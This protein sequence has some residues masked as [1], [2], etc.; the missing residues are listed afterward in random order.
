M[1]T[2]EAIVVINHARYS[3]AASVPL[4]VAEALEAEVRA[5][6]E[7]VESATRMI[8]DALEESPND[9]R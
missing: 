5:Y 4:E 7:G 2:D 8:D 1:T 6:R 9:D 3:G